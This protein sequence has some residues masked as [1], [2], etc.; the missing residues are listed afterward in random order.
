MTIEQQAEQD[1]QRAIHF[2]RFLDSIF[3]VK[4]DKNIMR[5]LPKKP[6]TEE[7][8]MGDV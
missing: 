3:G 8:F 5:N 1:T 4:V 7:I 6:L 2:G